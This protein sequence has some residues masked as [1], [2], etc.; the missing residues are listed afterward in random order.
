MSDKLVFYHGTMPSEFARQPRSLDEFKRF[1]ATEFR[2]F[3]LYT[4]QI[5][6][7]NILS[8]E[9]YQNFMCFSI[10]VSLMSNSNVVKQ[11]KYLDYAK[12]LMY[13]FVSNLQGLY[14]PQFYFFNVNALLHVIQSV[15]GS[16][17]VS[18]IKTV[19]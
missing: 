6:L 9:V 11:Q 1:K 14:G 15:H 10:A 19:Y 17:S 13:H 2:Q 5:I 16:Q 7:K 3:L 18:I 12:N 4:G 8:K